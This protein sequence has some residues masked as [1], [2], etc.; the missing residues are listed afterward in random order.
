MEKR[1]LAI[2]SKCRTCHLKNKHLKELT[3][4]G[5]IQEDYNQVESRI[6]NCEVLFGFEDCQ[7]MIEVLREFKYINDNNIPQLKT[8]VA[9]ELG[10]GSE[11]IFIAE[12]IME[13]VMDGLPPEQIVPL[14]SVFV[15]HGRSRDE[16]SVERLE[17]PDS[18]YEAIEKV[19]LSSPNHR[20]SRTYTARLRTPR[21]RKGYLQARSRTF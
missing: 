5:N 4:T 21:T 2:N 6:Q 7:Q 17:I 16:I 19:S 15:A 14:V 11:N 13:N 12:M 10:G 1:D 9:R 18:L 3:K 8:R 20:R